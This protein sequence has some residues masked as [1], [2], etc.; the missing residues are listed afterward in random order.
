MFI[1]TGCLSF[2][3]FQLTKQKVGVHINLCVHT[4]LWTILYVTTSVCIKR[5]LRS[6]RLPFLTHW[7]TACCS[8]LS[9]LLWNLPLQQRE[10]GSP[11]H[12]LVTQLFN[13]SLCV[14]QC[15]W[16]PCAPRKQLYQST[17]LMCILVCVFLRLSFS[18]FGTRSRLWVENYE[19]ELK[20]SSV[21]FPQPMLSVRYLN[22]L[23]SCS[24]NFCVQV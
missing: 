17:V 3:P 21:S 12:H 10:P 6:H 19:V 22:F 24:H 8:F 14:W 13:P 5:G 16:L 1:A 11:T 2:R 23:D 20:P 18:V 9:L 15:W 7:R 4:Y